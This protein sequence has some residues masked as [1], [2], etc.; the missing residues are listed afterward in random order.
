MNTHCHLE[1]EG[2]FHLSGDVF[3]IMERNSKPDGEQVDDCMCSMNEK[4]KQK[5]AACAQGVSGR[6]YCRE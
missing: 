1:R 4:K 6:S 2:I 5:I 3:E